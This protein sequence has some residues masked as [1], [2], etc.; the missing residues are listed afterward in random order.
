M[1]TMDQLDKAFD[2]TLTPGN[3]KESMKL[4]GAKSGDLWKVPPSMLHE[5]NGFNVRLLTPRWFAR[6]RSLADSMKRTGY[7]LHKPMTGYAGKD[8]AGKDTIYITDGY[9]RRAAIE[10]A[11]SELP[12]DKQIT[13]VSVVTHDAQKTT[14]VELNTQLIA[15][16]Q[17]SALLPYES[18]IVIDR[19]AKAG[20]SIDAIA[21]RTGFSTEWVQGL[22]SLIAAPEGLR[23]MVADDVITAT[24]AIDTIKEH[25]D[26]AFEVLQEALAQ[27]V[28]EADDAD[29]D[30]TK[31]RLTKKD[32]V[33]KEV[34]K[35]NNAVK[36]SAPGLYSAL[37]D[38][39]KDPNFAALAPET[40]DKLAKLMERL[41]KLEVPGALPSE[42][43]AVDP[44]QNALFDAE[45]PESG[46][47][48]QAA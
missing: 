48:E 12:K 29:G 14:M 44:R 3:L 10:L 46:A 24:F 13:V 9:T 41:E 39:K 25:G 19:L 15:G 26:K 2:L 40:R 47:G 6:V 38:V 17:E 28:G 43:P 5:I 45:A 1:Y 35:F 4:A 36:K 34:R 11:N 7:M 31:V 22:L 37:A 27:K 42:E 30:T 21:A 23:R 18:A 20:E 16:N 33:P 32:M 8:A